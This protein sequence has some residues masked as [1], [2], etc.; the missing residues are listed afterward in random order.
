MTFLDFEPTA[1]ERFARD[2][3]GDAKGPRVQAVGLFLAVRD[4]VRCDPFTTRMTPECFRASTVVV[5]RVALCMPKAVLLAAGAAC[6]AFP[7]RSGRR[8]W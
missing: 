8:T 6:W 1:V 2:V 4:S 7:P 3:V 5:E